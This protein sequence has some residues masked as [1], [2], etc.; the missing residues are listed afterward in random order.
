MSTRSVIGYTALAGIAAAGI[1]ALTQIDTDKVAHD[2]VQEK[3][4]APYQPLDYATL[5]DELKHESI[6]GDY[7]LPIAVSMGTLMEGGGSRAFNAN[8]IERNMLH[9]H[10]TRIRHDGTNSRQGM[11]TYLYGHME[12]IIINWITSDESLDKHLERAK[13]QLEQWGGTVSRTM[14]TGFIYNRN[15]GQQCLFHTQRHGDRI[16]DVNYSNVNGVD[17]QSLLVQELIHLQVDTFKKE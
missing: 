16:F 17:M 12:T 14:D 7:C 2:L 8:E 1:Y 4:P 11:D 9:G 6:Y 3:A 10:W 5:D 13:A 15:D